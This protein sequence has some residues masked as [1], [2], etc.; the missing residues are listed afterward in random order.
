MD[1][2]FDLKKGKKVKIEVNEISFTINDILKKYGF[3]YVGDNFDFT[4]K[5]E[6]NT[7]FKLYKKDNKL[8]KLV[9]LENFNTWIYNFTMQELIEKR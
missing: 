4:K 9:K 3:E 8:Y 2:N 7:I 1:K 6:V 5:R